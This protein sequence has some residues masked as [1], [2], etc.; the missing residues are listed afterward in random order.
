M[1][2]ISNA[3][4]AA[5]VKLIRVGEALAARAHPGKPVGVDAAV[6][7]LPVLNGAHV[8]PVV[9]HY[10]GVPDGSARFSAAVATQNAAT[11]RT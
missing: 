11:R 8:Q 2:S 9:A 1:A 3:K 4:Q 5:A 6:G 10:D 7:R